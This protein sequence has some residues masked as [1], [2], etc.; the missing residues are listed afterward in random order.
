MK[1]ARRKKT[2]LDL[3][4]YIVLIGGIVL[5]TGFGISLFISGQ[6]VTEEVD[7]KVSRDVDYL[8]AFI[9][10]N[11]NIIETVAHSLGSM[12]FGDLVTDDSGNACIIL[13]DSLPKAS[14]QKIYAA[15]TK[16]V[17]ANPA[18]CG[19]AI[20]F[21]PSVYPE[22]KSKYGFTPYV[23][24]VSG[25]LLSHDLGEMTY[26]FDWEWYKVTSELGHGYWAS[27]FQDSSIGHVIA[28]YS[29]PVL[30][31]GSVYAVIAVDIDTEAFTRKCAEISPYPN[32]QVALLDRNFNFI[33]HPDP[34]YLMKNVSDFEEENAAFTDEVK[35]KMS[36]GMTGN[37]SLSYG[38]KD[39]I[40]YFAPVTRTGW[41]I[42]IECPKDEIFGGVDHML[43]STTI[44]ALVCIL[45]ISLILT[46]LFRRFQKI[47]ISE[48]SI[49]KDL[50]TAS[51][52]QNGMLPRDPLPEDCLGLSLS[53]FLKPAKLVGGDLFYHFCRDG[54]LFFCIG[55]VS[56]K[57]V[58]ASLYMVTTLA[59]FLNITRREDDARKIVTET[60]ALLASKNFYSMFCTMFLGVFDP[61]TGR[62]DYC[63]AGH[64]RPILFRASDGKASF[65][66]VKANIAMGIMEDFPFVSEEVYLNRGDAL[67]LYTDGVT[68]AEDTGKALFGD[69]ATL[70]TVDR[71]FRI[72]GLDAGARI[73]RIYE[74]LQKHTGKAAQNDDITM[75]M[76]QNRK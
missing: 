69:A 21:D 20:E 42:S 3:T 60:N 28:C 37:F 67:F 39:F 51:L 72:P 68:E 71:T 47:F 49:E 8:Q 9:D 19:I 32:A 74:A 7:K 59:L 55:D 34:G 26:S 27:P 65:L 12:L 70:E 10:G 43:F 57:G 46:G 75:L 23:T 54:K 24:N 31:D 11:L 76:I 52:I 61:E 48:A 66:D 29:V 45:L 44:I 73:E 1:Q 13:S 18:V 22:V 33:S 63:N 62:L 15:M 17:T 14:P 5:T 50:S 36:L 30:R 25:K 4:L 53:G 38:R 2:F 58:S 16:F 41:I 35:R 40:Y 64:N 56:G 6:E